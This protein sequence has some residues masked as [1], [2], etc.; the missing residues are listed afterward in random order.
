MSL[1]ND[2]FASIGSPTS[3]VGSSPSSPFDLS[4]VDDYG[5]HHT[6]VRGSKKEH[7]KRPM[8]AFMVWAQL[9]RRKMTLEYPDM[10]NAEISRR[11]GK[12]W[13]LLGEEEK[14]PFIEESERLRVQH[15][16]QYP[17][18]KYRPRKKGVKKTTTTK[19]AGS[20]SSS[21]LQYLDS[22]SDDGGCTCG[23]NRRPVQTSNIAVQC[24]MEQGEHIIERDHSP[25]AVQTAEIS[26]Q[27]G[28]GSAHLME[29]RT[30]HR[31]SN[32]Y[33]QIA[34]A[35]EKRP[36]ELPLTTSSPGYTKKPRIDTPTP[37]QVSTSTNT[38]NNKRVTV[39][40]VFPPSPPSSDSSPIS[41]HE[42][43]LP[44]LDYFDN[45]LDPIIP[46]DSKS[47]LDMPL[48]NHSSVSSASGSTLVPSNTAINGHITS[49]AAQNFSPFQLDP[50]GFDFPDISS[51]FSDIFGQNVTADFD[52]NITALL[53][54]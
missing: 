32:R 1:S 54:A 31:S 53:S 43:L 4:S 40:A 20:S 23:G 22:F 14:Q 26:I 2:T 29:T 35:G 27:V 18:Y 48:S 8:N 52:S 49:S 38:I 3:S 41:P 30:M 17:D 9:E 51:D 34:I 13:R 6:V 33:Q 16:K 50:T 21:H 7:I 44:R 24:S 5:A 42:D 15:M 37:E 45:F 12:L 25:S 39:P 11:L 28:N 47:P 36:K 19:I 10:H 46:F